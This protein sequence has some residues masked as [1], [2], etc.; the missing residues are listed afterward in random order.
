MVGVIAALAPLPPLLKWV[1]GKRE[2]LKHIAP[3]LPT[4]YARYFEP[5]VGG[6]ALFFAMR[7]RH[8]LLADTNA[9]LTEC[10]VQVRDHADALI[11]YLGTLRNSEKDYYEIRATAPKEPLQRAARLI[12]LTTLAFNGIHRLNL[13]GEFNVPYGRKMHINP[14]DPEKIRCASAALAGAEV[15]CADFE[16]AVATARE[17]DLVYLD[18][19][20]TVAHANN[21]FLKY[22]AKIFSWQDQLRLAECARKLSR[23]GCR[24]VVS[25]ADHHSIRGLYTSFSCTV[26][27]RQSRMAASKDHR[28]AVTECL[29]YDPGG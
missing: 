24:V 3:L 21:G 14:C 20:Y 25:N 13:K 22:N 15:L 26:V 12:Y 17:G 19:P 1:G 7:P 6:G 9:D 27:T 2:I 4:D 23:R 10:Y 8:A 16:E 5:F 29:F 18:P 11:T 28:R